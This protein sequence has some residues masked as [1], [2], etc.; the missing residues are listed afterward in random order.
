MRVTHGIVH[1]QMQVMNRDGGGNSRTKAFH[2]R[3]RRVVENENAKNAEPISEI[4]QKSCCIG[5]IPR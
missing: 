2:L 5:W 1:G 3:E 4:M